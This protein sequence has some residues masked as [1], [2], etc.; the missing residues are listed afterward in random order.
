M[1]SFGLIWQI[2]RMKREGKAMIFVLCSFFPSFA[3]E[4]YSS[5]IWYWIWMG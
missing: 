5:V 3:D 2:Q 4:F 1:M